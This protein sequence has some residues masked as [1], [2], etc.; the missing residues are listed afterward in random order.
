MCIR[1]SL[2]LEQPKNHFTMGIVDDVTFH[3]LEVGAPVDLSLIHI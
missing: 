3:S 2:K 1:D